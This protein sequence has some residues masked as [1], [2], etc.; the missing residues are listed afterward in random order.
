[1]QFKDYFKNEFNRD[2]DCVI[3]CEFKAISQ[4]RPH[5]IN[6]KVKLVSGAHCAIAK[7]CNQSIATTKINELKIKS[8]YPH[9]EMGD[10]LKAGE[11]SI[12]QSKINKLESHKPNPL[13]ISKKRRKIH[14][15]HLLDVCSQKNYS[16]GFIVLMAGFSQIV[17]LD[18]TAKID[19]LSKLE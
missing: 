12:S 16:V 4:R 14:R 19:D 9:L 7:C 13:A 5:E 1:M 11:I 17:K 3:G 10:F 2:S 18:H 15:V 6:A 8:F